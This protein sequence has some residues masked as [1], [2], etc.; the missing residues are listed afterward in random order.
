MREE[1]YIVLTRILVSQNQIADALG[2]SEKLIESAQ[3]SDRNAATLEVLL[4]Q[5]LAYQA[6]GDMNQAL[7]VLGKALKLAEKGGAVRIF[8]DE[9]EPMAELLDAF[10][11]QSSTINGEFLDSLREGFRATQM[12]AE[13]NIIEDRIAKNG[14]LLDPLSDRELEVLRLLAAALSY[15]EIA[16]ELFVSINTVKAHT[17]NIYSKMGVHGRMQAAQRAKELHLI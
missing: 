6:Q 16:E 9:G 15:R 13:P 4:I 3:A 14:G 5:A 11:R 8:L 2:L 12:Q 1:E 7:A 10:S 17:K